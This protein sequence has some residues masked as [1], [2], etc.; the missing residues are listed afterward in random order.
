VTKRENDPLNPNYKV[1]GHSEML[2]QNP[3]GNRAEDSSMG[4]KFVLIKKQLEAKQEAEKSKTL[5]QVVGNE[6]E[7]K[8]DM[9]KFYGVNPGATKEVNLNYFVGQVGAKEK[10]NNSERANELQ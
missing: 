8:K 7:F 6:Q 3:Y 2:I 10:E 1:P 5:K 9:A 4:N